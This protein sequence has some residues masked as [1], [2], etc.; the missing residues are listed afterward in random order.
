MFLYSNVKY[1]TEYHQSTTLVAAA[2]LCN[3][4]KRMGPLMF[5]HPPVK[6]LLVLICLLNPSD[7]PGCNA[8]PEHEKAEKVK[9]DF[10]TFLTTQFPAI[11]CNSLQFLAIPHNYSLFIG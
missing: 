2:P 5:W 1:E 6:M 11:P 4:L 10:L 3:T 9:K 7:H 8:S